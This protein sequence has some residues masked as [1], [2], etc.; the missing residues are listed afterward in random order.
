MFYTGLQKRNVAISKEI[1]EIYFEIQFISIKVMFMFSL[2]KTGNAYYKCFTF[3]L[4]KIMRNVVI[5]E[6]LIVMARLAVRIA[7][8]EFLLNNR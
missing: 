2:K 3:D 8:I 6:D 7:K 4:A 1:T 5:F